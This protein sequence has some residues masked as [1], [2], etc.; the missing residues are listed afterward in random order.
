M[1]HDNWLSSLVKAFTAAV[2]KFGIQEILSKNILDE[3]AQ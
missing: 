3:N 1:F 2:F